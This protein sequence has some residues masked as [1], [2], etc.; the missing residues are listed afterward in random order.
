V[1]GGDVPAPP[2]TE[3]RVEQAKI[4]VYIRNASEPPV[5]VKHVEYTIR[6]RW[7]VPTD[8]GEWERVDGTLAGPY[9]LKDFQVRPEE[10]WDNKRTPYEVTLAHT[11]PE[12]AV[13]LDFLQGVDC[14]INSVVVLDNAGRQW[15]IRP[16]G[17]G[18][19][20][21]SRPVAPRSSGA[22]RAKL[23]GGPECEPGPAL[24]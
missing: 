21:P 18:R 3:P 19:A 7:W 12:G 2:P 16:N 9:Y 17:G 14:E 24:V 5:D 22:S 11:A 10:T 6:T 23:L 20:K 15:E 1:G 13:Q 8:D 4:Q